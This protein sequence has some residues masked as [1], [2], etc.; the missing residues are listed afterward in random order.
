MQNCNFKK[1]MIT[2]L[3]QMFSLLQTVSFDV[4]SW[5]ICFLGLAFLTFFKTRKVFLTKLTVFALAFLDQILIFDVF[6]TGFAVKPGS[7]EIENNKEKSL[8]R[9]KGRHMFRLGYV[10]LSCNLSYSE[11]EQRPFRWAKY[12]ATVKYHTAQTLD[13]MWEILSNGKLQSV[14][15]RSFAP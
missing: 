3:F 6:M 11:A 12:H 7:V 13:A 4:L 1:M 5:K 8:T 15:R 2:T 14:L 9:R 10:A